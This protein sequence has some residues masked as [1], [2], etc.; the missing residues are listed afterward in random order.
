MLVFGRLGR[1]TWWEVG[2]GVG[3]GEMV[4]SGGMF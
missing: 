4:G 3:V 1:G 2:L